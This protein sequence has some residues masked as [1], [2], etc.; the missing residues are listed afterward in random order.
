MERE[1]N[2]ALVGAFVLLVAVA[3]GLFVYWYSD[4]REH[5]DY[6]RYEIYFDGSV[7]G[8]S[9][10]GP[11]RYLGVDIGRVVS[12]RIDRRAATRVQVEVDIDSQTP[13]S[14]QTLAELSLQGVTG[15][16]YI[17]LFRNDGRKQA[18]PAVPGERYPV[19][20]SVR[21]NFDIFVSSLPDLV[22]KVGEV[23]A[24]AAALVS[25]KNIAAF[26][27]TLQSVDRATARLPE[28]MQKIDSLAAEL[29]TA[30]ADARIVAA[31][32]RSISEESGPE[33][34]VMAQRVR[35]AADNLATTTARLDQL[36]AENRGD[37]R[38]FTRDS[39]PQI[40]EFVRDSRAAAQE[41]RD[42]SRSLRENPSRLLYQP[43]PAGVEIPR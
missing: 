8:L 25:D 16:L 29:H 41:F 43:A 12:M 23:A 31:N 14:D 26:T 5:R 4:S 36:L 42:L 18:A 19:I 15:T 20:R 30:A 28:T 37:L 9:R 10:G 1:A 2:Y 40:E 6:K 27:N 38:A 11:V 32:V 33:I 13:V 35:T 17:D 39:L 22:A 7:S 21:S 3:A 34:K 24:R